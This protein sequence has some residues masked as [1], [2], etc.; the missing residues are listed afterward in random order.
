MILTE[1]TVG[2]KKKE[3]RG[4]IKGLI[5][6]MKKEKKGITIRREAGKGTQ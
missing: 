1:A 3:K 6:F 4:L 5:L 2:S